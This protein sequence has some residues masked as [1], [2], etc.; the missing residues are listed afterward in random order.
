MVFGAH[1]SPNVW[2]C[3]D[4]YVMFQLIGGLTGARNNKALTEWMDSENM[5]PIF[6]K[7]RD[8]ANWDFWNASQDEVDALAEAIRPFF[9]A[10]T[11][12]ELQE[13]AIKR[14]IM[15]Y[16]VSD[17]A[18]TVNNVQLKARNYWINI[19]HD[20]LGD[21]ITYPGAFAKLSLTPIAHWRRAPLIGE[22]NDEIYGKE[23]GLS[24]DELAVLKTNGII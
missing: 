10:H 7:E 5:A 1:I 2:E 17:S 14:R 13:G 11:K 12:E 21:T 3:K 8:W 23:L 18:D 19:E 16:K 22:H 15:L 6:M 20:E 4:G 24:E 9:K